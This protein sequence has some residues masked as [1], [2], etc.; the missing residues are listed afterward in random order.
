MNGTERD[1]LQLRI[2]TKYTRSAQN[3]VNEDIAKDMDGNT[4]ILTNCK[5]WLLKKTHLKLASFPI[6][7]R[8]RTLQLK[9]PP[10][11]QQFRQVPQHRRQ[12]PRPSHGIS[13]DPVE[14]GLYN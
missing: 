13:H 6:S 14:R 12:V 3:D 8:T 1:C 11:V 9:M 10:S 5:Q 4:N 7:C 2:V